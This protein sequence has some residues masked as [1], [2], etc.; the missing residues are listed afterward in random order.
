MILTLYRDNLLKL[1]Q[2]LDPI[3]GKVHTRSPKNRLRLHYLRKAPSHLI[4]LPLFLLLTLFFLLFCGSELDLTKFYCF[5]TR[6]S[7]A[8]LTA[9]LTSPR[10]QVPFGFFM[11]HSQRL[12]L[13]FS[14]ISRKALD[15]PVSAS[16]FLMRSRVQS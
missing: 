10:Q 16:S 4:R 13:T 6:A 7:F 11:S 8:S 3:D 2:I 14:A 1:L 5:T 15:C 9:R 12:A